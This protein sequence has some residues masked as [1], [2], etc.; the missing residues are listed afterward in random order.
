MT[1]TAKFV[2]SLYPP[3]S[4]KYPFAEK[5]TGGGAMALT[6]GR[7][8]TTNYQTGEWQGFEGTDL[9]VIIDLAKEKKIDEVSTGFLQDTGVWIFLPDYVEY[10]VS[11]DG[12]DFK[13]VAEIKNDLDPRK[14]SLLV[15]HFIARLNAIGARYLKIVAKNIGVCPPWHVGAGGKAWLFVDEITIK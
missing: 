7:A 4:Y 6:D 3:A 2:K 15:K 9:D 12:K 14:H 10:F 13:K 5:Y 1:S 11:Q 8:G